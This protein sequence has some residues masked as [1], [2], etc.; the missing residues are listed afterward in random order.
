VSNSKLRICV[1][2]GIEVDGLDAIV[3]KEF[4]FKIEISSD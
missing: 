2:F 4:N 1:R 3:D